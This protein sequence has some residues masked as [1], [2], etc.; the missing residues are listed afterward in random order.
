MSK[1]L[2]V[3]VMVCA[4]ARADGT[5]SG[6]GSGSGSAGPK[7]IIIQIP[8]DVVAPK[9]SASAS[10]TVARLGKSITLFIT[11]ERPPGVEVNLAEPVE[12]GGA[13]EVRRKLSVEDKVQPDGSKLREWQLEVTP[14]EVGELEIPQLGVTFTSN[15]KAGQVATNAVPVRVVALLGDVDDPTQLRPLEPPRTLVSPDWTLLYAGAAAA[16]AIVLVLAY[17]R[18]RRRRRTRT[19]ALVAGSGIIPR[20]MDMTSERALEQL[21]AIERS[22][23]LDRDEDR[24]RGYVAMFEVVRE[25]LG[26]RYRVASLDLTTSELVRRLERV[27][28]SGELA[29]VESWL[30]R[31]DL[32]R[33]GGVRPAHAEARTAL[34]DARGVILATTDIDAKAAA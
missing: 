25:Y 9:V 27:A 3:L 13:F 34:G 4:V 14:W 33:Y 32:V 10:P 22:G 2:A 7:K 21:L 11:A 12:L 26:A 8:D 17:L 6:S 18:F 5:G 23:D 31:C 29:L 24:R 1:A 30:E 20:H 15:G 16:G 19:Y 28:G